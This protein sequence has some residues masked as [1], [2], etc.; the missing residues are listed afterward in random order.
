MGKEVYDFV[1]WR[2]DGGQVGSLL[3][4]KYVMPKEDCK[5]PDFFKNGIK[6]NKNNKKIKALAKREK[7][8]IRNYE[9]L[10]LPTGITDFC[11]EN[12]KKKWSDLSE[13]YKEFTKM[14]S[15]DKGAK[16]QIFITKLLAVVLSSYFIR[17]ALQQKDIRNTYPI[18]NNYTA[19]YAIIKKTKYDDDAYNLRALCRSFIVSTTK[20]ETD[21]FKI[22]APILLPVKGEKRILDAAW[23]RPKRFK[24]DY[25]WPAPYRDMTVMLDGRF[26]NNSDMNKFLSINPWCTAIIL[27]DKVELTRFCIKLDG[28]NILNQME[29]NWNIDAV[30]KLI[31]EYIPFIYNTFDKRSHANDAQDRS[32]ADIWGEAGEY[33]TNYMITKKE[34]EIG[35]AERFKQRILLSA[36]ISFV[37]FLYCSCSISLDEARELKRELLTALLPGCCPPKSEQEVQV[38]QFPAFDEILRELISPENMNHFYPIIKRGQVHPTELS[39]GTEVWGYVRRYKDEKSQEKEINIAFFGDTLIKI[40]EEKYPQCGY[41]GNVLTCVKK[42]KPAYLHDTYNIRCRTAEGKKQDTISGYR[43]ILDKLP[44]S[45]EVKQAFRQ[46]LSKNAK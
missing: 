34:G 36:L 40:V 10:D 21:K 26:F 38:I 5:C 22:K 13:C 41:F 30:N 14:L 15:P 24:D 3:L 27:A 39:D 6:P 23:L 29:I 1:Y 8:K 9:P 18:S 46:M 45:E 28:K 16:T 31:R 43:L 11:V 7:I 37:D 17:M 44:V 42:S 32:Y 25:K 20:R 4:W 33:L 19:L 2:Y 35:Y 12:K